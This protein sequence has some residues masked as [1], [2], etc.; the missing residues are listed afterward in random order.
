MGDKDNDGEER[1][2]V[3]RTVMV[4]VRRRVMWVMVRREG[5]QYG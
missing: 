2:V 1:V 5:E 4:M 3:I